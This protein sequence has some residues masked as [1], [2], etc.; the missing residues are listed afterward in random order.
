MAS[1]IFVDLEDFT[2][3][4]SPIFEKLSIFP[5]NLG[6][7]EFEMSGSRHGG[8]LVFLNGNREVSELE[9]GLRH[10]RDNDYIFLITDNRSL[11]PTQ[12]GNLNRFLLSHNSVRGVIE[13]NQGF[14][15]LISQF[16]GLKEIADLKFELDADEE[17]IEDFE[18]QLDEVAKHLST[19]L[20]RIKEVHKKVVPERSIKLKDLTLKCKFA[21]GE[22]NHAEFWDSVKT[23]RTLAC[24]ILSTES[25]T[26]LT[27]V[28]TDIIDFTNTLEF[29]KEH[30]KRLYNKIS[31]TLENKFSLFIL[32]SDTVSRKTYL[33]SHGN[34]LVFLNGREVIASKDGKINKMELKTNDRFVVFS[35]GLIKNYDDDY[36]LEDLETIGR[37]K[38]ELSS[39]DFF[40]E[41]FF[42]SKI[43]NPGKFHKYDCT[44][45]ILSVDSIETPSKEDA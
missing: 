31:T 11:S 33:I 37:R 10:S 9:K 45:M 21:S 32:V 12:E 27:M 25:S 26:D 5:E 29:E 3:K 15:F 30:L 35:E 38:W 28:L 20:A 19:Q 4:A 41:V 39:R 14:G 22:S 18:S 44:A 36:R 34:Q 13:S 6:V 42:N 1:W 2:K 17:Y 16:N 40:N 43:T 8:D 24:V 7:Q 23:D